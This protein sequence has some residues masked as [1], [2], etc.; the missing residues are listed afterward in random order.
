MDREDEDALE[1]DVGW[2]DA[3][4][5]ALAREGGV[6]PGVVRTPAD[7]PRR[8]APPRAYQRADHR[9]RDDVYDRLCG[10]TGADASE[11][12]VAVHGGVVTLT[13][14]VPDG[15]DE[16][17]VLRLAERVTGVQRV[18]NFLRVREGV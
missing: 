9:I 2:E 4:D 10:P 11:V 17:R 12:V 8:S 14:A 6:P 16:R 1:P 15:E 5:E 3:R 18:V 13:G 7:E